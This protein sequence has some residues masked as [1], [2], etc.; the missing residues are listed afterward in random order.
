MELSP[1]LARDDQ[2]DGYQP[3]SVRCRVC[4]AMVAGSDAVDLR[5]AQRGHQVD[6]SPWVCRRCAPA[7]APSRGSNL[8]KPATDGQR[9]HIARLA[10]QLAVPPPH[11]STK[12]EADRAIR[13]VLS[14]A[15]SP[16]H[17][18]RERLGRGR[19]ATSHN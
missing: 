1:G 6:R 12:A 5:T 13:D 8:S 7:V 4:K 17:H 19:Q 16:G 11:V 2:L 18:G 15:G 9:E 14:G 3:K 10:R